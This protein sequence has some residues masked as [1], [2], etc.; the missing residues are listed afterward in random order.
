[1][2]R[3]AQSAT[4]GAFN[5]MKRA[6]LL[7]LITTVGLTL[8]GCMAG[9]VLAFIAPGFYRRIFVAAGDDAF[10]ALEVG[11]GSGA[12]LGFLAGAAVIAVRMVASI[13]TDLSRQRLFGR[14]SSQLTFG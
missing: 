5:N 10:D 9:G 7:A 4:A 1:M 13:L 3:R 12:I 6:I 14:G 11:V 2:V 8:A